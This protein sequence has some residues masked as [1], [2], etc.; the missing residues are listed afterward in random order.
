MPAWLC[1][2]GRWLTLLLLVGVGQ[3]GLFVWQLR[4]I[5]KSLGPAEQAARAAAANAQAMIDNERPWI[6]VDTVWS[7]KLEAGAIIQE[8]FVR[9]KNWQDASSSDAGCFQRQRIA[10]RH[11]TNCARCG[12]GAAE[13]AA[14]KHAGPLLSVQ[15][16]YAISS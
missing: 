13:A 4:L 6:G 8:A 12:I 2:L 14:S 1:N 11:P 3:V 5:R 10:C 9:I 15:R 16:L 7:E